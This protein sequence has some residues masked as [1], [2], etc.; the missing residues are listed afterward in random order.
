MR[1]ILIAVLVLLVA[2]SAG[3]YIY[4]YQPFGGQTAIEALLP[5]DT[6][7]MVRVRGLK[8]QIQRFKT[9]KMGRSLTAIDMPLFLD[10]MGVAPEQKAQILSA[11]ADFN[12]VI[13]STWF[14]VLFGKDIAL[15]VQK[16]SLDSELLA[17]DDIQPLRDAFVVVGR[18]KHPTK[19]LES[20]NSMFAT[21]LDVRSEAY[22]QWQ[23]NHFE[24]ENG[25]VVYYALT[26]E[27]LIAGPSIAP[28]KQCLAQS[29]D[30]STSLMH[31]PVFKRYCAGMIKP[32]NTHWVAFADM[33]YLLA[34]AGD[35]LDHQAQRKPEAAQLH[36]HLAKV[37]GLESFNLVSYGDDGPVVEVKTV[38]G[39]DEPS[40][41]E[42]LRQALQTPPANNPTLKLAP[43]GTLLYSWQNGF[44]L[45]R[46]W[47]EGLQSGQI[48]PEK[49]QQ[50]LNDVKLQLGMPLEDILDALGKQAGLLLF[51]L[52][53]EGL[54]PV[55]EIALYI[56]VQQPETIHRLIQGSIERH[57]GRS[58]SAEQYNGTAL[59]YL[60]LP[61]G[62][63][64]SPAYAI[65]DNFCAVAVNRR[66]LKR[67]LDASGQ[68]G[69]AA[70]EDFKTIGRGLTEKNNQIFFVQSD[71]MARKTRQ[72][73]TWVMAWANLVK[74]RQRVQLGPVI[75][76]VVNPVLDGLT[77]V[78]TVSGRTF[79]EKDCISSEVKMVLDRD[80]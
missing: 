14:D 58:M 7:V 64:L 55:P 57:M 26:D 21:Q 63:S 15:A 59:H 24:L 49:Q 44:D 34:T 72:A 9:G 71:Q 48:S 45:K 4:L 73:L 3:A 56:Q 8:A 36:K 47:Q 60:Q 39:L 2:A 27:F 17:S 37:K 40:M 28:V 33:Q 69:L 19:V 46:L 68:G 20:L 35:I 52:N 18:P 22:Q 29:M 32:A 30:A 66:L 78:R 43:A 67:M 74:T 13:D 75:D 11:I 31:S 50:I 6:A 77:M 53:M 65:A 62:E 1:K 70:Q 25:A 76:V 12:R 51:D 5:T 38:I 54:F 41:S 80:S 16:V 61:L 10:T 23:I 79:V 42:S